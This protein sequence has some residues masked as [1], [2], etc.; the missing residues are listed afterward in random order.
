MSK[1]DCLLIS[2]QQLLIKIVEYR[3]NRQ[4]RLIY[5]SDSD[6]EMVDLEFFDEPGPVGPYK[7]G[8]WHS[9]PF[10]TYG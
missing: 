3:L 9:V 1:F 7:E 2:A 4:N 8:I 5:E 6:V 10:G